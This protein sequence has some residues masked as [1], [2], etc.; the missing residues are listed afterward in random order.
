HDQ[1]Q[2]SLFVFSKHRHPQSELLSSGVD[3]PLCGRDFIRAVVFTC[4]G[5]RWKRHLAELRREYQGKLPGSSLPA[6]PASQR[7]RGDP[8]GLGSSTSPAPLNP[9]SSKVNTQLPGCSLACLSSKDKK[10]KL[11]ISP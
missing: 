1:K 3:R 9:C 2:S 4:G 10:H 11:L 7:I 6:A 8:R 5:S